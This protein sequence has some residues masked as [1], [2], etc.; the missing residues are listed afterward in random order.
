M[1]AHAGRVLLHMLKKQRSE[2][3][4]FVIALFFYIIKKKLLFICASN[5]FIFNGK[6]AGDLPSSFSYPFQRRPP[7]RYRIN[8]FFC[9]EKKK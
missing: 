3:I 6:Q 4:K 7:Q 9:K 5:M 1:R 2:M 8:L